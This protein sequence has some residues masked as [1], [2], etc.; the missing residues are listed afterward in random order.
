MSAYAHFFV[1]SRLINNRPASSDHASRICRLLFNQSLFLHPRVD[2]R[3]VSHDKTGD[4]WPGADLRVEFAE[5]SEVALAKI[6]G[7]LLDLEGVFA[8]H[9]FT[10][11]IQ[12]WVGEVGLVTKDKQ[13]KS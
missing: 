10:L 9:F 4:C 13:P 12:S 7:N 8:F 11:T 5:A 3:E 1:Y 6:D 2:L